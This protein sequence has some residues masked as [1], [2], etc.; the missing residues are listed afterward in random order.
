[1]ASAGNS[2]T[3]AE[4]ATRARHSLIELY[5][6]KDK[7]YLADCLLANRHTR[8]KDAIKDMTLRSNG[9][10]AVSLDV[11][12]GEKAR[13][14]VLC[15]LKHLVIP[16]AIRSLAPLEVETPLP[17]HDRMGHL[18][19]NPRFPY[20]G[21]Y[22]GDEDTSRKPAYH[23]GTAWT[24]PFPGFCEALAKAWN[25]QDAATRSA[26]SYLSS[27]D[28]LLTSGCLG[29]LSEILDG[30]APHTQRGCDAQAWGATEALRVWRWLQSVT[31]K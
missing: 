26:R 4:L 6:D 17:I 27:M 11:I 29:H 13:S 28:R 18:V 20:C 7:G 15:A 22:T 8:A 19:N 31:S 21:T 23:N 30:N 5:W 16:G 12:Q 9:L 10:F 14:I 25:C 3:W 2:P 24:W 1:V